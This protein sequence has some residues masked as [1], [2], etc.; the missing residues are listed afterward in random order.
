MTIARTYAHYADQLVALL[1]GPDKFAHLIAGLTIWLFASLLFRRP[2][3]SSRPLASVLLV[4]LMLELVEL[5]VGRQTGW[6]EFLGDVVATMM[7]PTV[8]SIALRR[9][10]NR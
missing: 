1:P 4:E 8:L 5:I 3:A 2:L 10:P 9:S 6:S 7:W